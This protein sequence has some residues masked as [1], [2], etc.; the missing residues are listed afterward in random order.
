[1]YCLYRF[2]LI[3]LSVTFVFFSKANSLGSM[4][5]LDAEYVSMV[6]LEQLTPVI[7][8][9]PGACILPDT[10]LIRSGANTTESQIRYGLNGFY[11]SLSIAPDKVV[12]MV[13]IFIIL[14]SN[15]TL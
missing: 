9:L 7:R 8:S 13:M 2:V 12:S 5:G 1:M 10:L 6:I 3:F 4:Q 14:H 15:F 11:F